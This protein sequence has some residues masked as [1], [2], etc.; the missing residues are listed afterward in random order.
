MTDLPRYHTGSLGPIDFQTLN[1][2]FRRLDALRPIIEQASVKA[3]K[4]KAEIRPIVVFASRILEEDIPEGLPLDVPL[5]QWEQVI[6]RGDES[7]D[8]DKGPN[9]FVSPDDDD[10]ESARATATFRYGPQQY[11]GADPKKGKGDPET[12]EEGFG[13]CFDENFQGGFC[14]LIDSSRQDFKN[15]FVLCPIASSSRTFLAMITEGG[16]AGSS[17]TLGNCSGREAGREV[18]DGSEALAWA[19]TAVPLKPFQEGSSTKPGLCKGGPF[20]LYDFSLSNVNKPAS[21]V[22]DFEE[23]PLTAGNVVPVHATTFGPGLT[24]YYIGMLPRLDAICKD[25]DDKGVI[26]R[27]QV[28]R[29]YK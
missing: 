24:F 9:T 16:D 2:A 5:Y 28:L 17:F 25:E 4:E 26:A 29:T 12:R 19:Y 14:I 15:C 23:V 21:D 7:A 22:A 13:I 11:E 10:Y 1:E 3:S 6:V 20:V 8:E 27:R 18:G